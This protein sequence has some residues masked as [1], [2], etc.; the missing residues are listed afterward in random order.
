MLLPPTVSVGSG[1][2]IDS[3]GNTSKQIDI[4]IY[5]KQIC[6]VFSINDT[7]ET[8]YFPCEGVIAIGEVKSLLDT[9]ELEDSY[10]KIASV[11]RLKRHAEATDGLNGKLVAFRHYG[12]LTAYDPAPEEEFNQATKHSDQIFGFVFAGELGL[13]PKTLCDRAASIFSSYTLQTA[14]NLFVI[15][16]HGIMV[17]MNL[18]TKKFS[19]SP[20]NDMKGMY[21]T[22]KKP[23][24]FQ[25]L[26]RYLYSFVRIG[27]TT[28][29]KAFLRY[30][31]GDSATTLELGGSYS[32][33]TNDA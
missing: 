32:K 15:L 12:N 8:T 6:P 21:I 3:Y 27:R 22:S 1:C 9:K 25:A 20:L 5:E 28:S 29:S 2:V 18:E 24:N 26:L 11:K 14:P 23:D 17:Y 16:N 30:L 4:I 13:K 7:P 19:T 10:E 31:F 33:F